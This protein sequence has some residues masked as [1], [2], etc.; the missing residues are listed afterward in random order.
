MISFSTKQEENYHSN[1]KIILFL[2]FN[3]L[4]G[5]KLMSKYMQVS[6]TAVSFNFATGFQSLFLPC[7][8]EDLHLTLFSGMYRGKS[9]LFHL[10]AQISLTELLVTPQLRISCQVATALLP[11]NGSCGGLK[12]VSL[13]RELAK[14]NLFW[15]VKKRQLFFLF[16][17]S[18][19]L[20]GFGT[21]KAHILQTDTPKMTK[22]QCVKMFC[23]WP[24]ISLINEFINISVN[25]FSLPAFNYSKNLTE[26]LK[27]FLKAVHLRGL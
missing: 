23:Q 18:V 19:F 9:P 14:F 5:H 16:P 22:N 27:T 12:Q 2:W 6:I 7:L 25:I 17:P 4:F 1:V 13:Y 8:W 21:S 15:N 11:Q 10:Y 20:K 24:L 3:T 26:F